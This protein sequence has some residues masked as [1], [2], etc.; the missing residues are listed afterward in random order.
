MEGIL[1]LIL[2]KSSDPRKGIEVR[3]AG[4]KSKFNNIQISLIPMFDGSENED[5]R[6]QQQAIG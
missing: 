5:Q 6:R 4:M 1:F 2:A 3:R